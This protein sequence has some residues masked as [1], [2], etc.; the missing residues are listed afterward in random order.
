MNILVLNYEY[1]PLGGGAAPVSKDICEGLAEAGHTVCVVTMKIKGLAEFEVINGVNI[2]R[3]R[4]LRSKKDRCQP[5]EQLSYLFF[6][7]FFVKKLLLNNKFDV[8]HTHFIIPTGALGFMIKKMRKLPLVLTAHGSDVLGH[9]KQRFT[10][11]YRLL[12]RPWV[13]ICKSAD[14]I[15]S[16]SRHL[17]RRIQELSP[18]S[19]C[20]VIGN[21]IDLSR[22]YTAEK[23][24]KILVMSRLQKFK[25]VDTVIRAFARMQL[26]DWELH[27][28]GD[29]PY[30]S[31]LQNL[32]KEYGV[33]NNT[34]FH[35][36]LPDSGCEKFDLLASAKIYVLA[37]QF[38]NFPVVAVEA[39]ASG[40][41]P[42][43][44]D[45]P[46][47]REFDLPEELFFSYGSEVELAQRL[48]NLI[49]TNANHLDFDLDY[50][51]YSSS[52]MVQRYEDLLLQVVNRHV[53]HN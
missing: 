1:P 39:M 50:K 30:L 15:V 27:I 21:G 49:T 44:S 4:C 22:Y 35:G 25:G 40:C 31:E 14:E 24:N 48:E 12:K 47:L 2:Y 46:A 28:A 20:T 36:W 18:N 52:L 37:S 38:E 11:L 7:A 10:F 6:A 53:R 33:G 41:I 29:G 8:C 16:P 13:A 23:T 9:N 17:A 51:D 42:V 32:A 34:I 19:K 43:F 45:I 3:V 26:N 5:H